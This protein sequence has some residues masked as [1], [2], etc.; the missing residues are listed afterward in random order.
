M[1]IR[2]CSNALVSVVWK[3]GTTTWKCTCHGTLSTIHDQKKYEASLKK[4]EVAA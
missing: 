3:D 1:L 2:P 4:E